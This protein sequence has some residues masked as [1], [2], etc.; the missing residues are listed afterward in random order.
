MTL[1]PANAFKFENTK[2]FLSG[3]G[4]TLYKTVL[5]FHDPKKDDFRK[6]L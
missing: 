2:I 5:A 6:T 4:L 1:F 3:R